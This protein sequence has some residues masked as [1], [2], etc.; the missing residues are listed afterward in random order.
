MSLLYHQTFTKGLFGKY[1]AIF[2]RLPHQGHILEV[3]CHTGYF[4]RFLIDAGYHVIAVET[5][6]E[7]V[8]VAQKNGVSV[9]QANIENFD[10]AI[11]SQHKF[12]VILFMDVLEHL[13][14]PEAV[15]K[16]VIPLLNKDGRILITGPNTVYW[17]VRRDVLRGRWN[18]TD[19]GLL[20]R[21]HLRFYTSSTWYNLF[22]E[23]GFEVIRLESV[24]G[25]V[26]LA[27]YLGRLPL[28]KS[29]PSIIHRAG[30]KLLPN[31]F[32]ITFLIEATPMQS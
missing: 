13:R 11:F 3:G 22:K 23:N 9:I 2:E 16:S 14:Y 30:M 10:P 17:S 32:T 18:Y 28:C 15:L 31:L 4:S 19:S 20:D 25:I 29:L 5:D 24:D 6:Q 21:T 1:K 7:A 27:H 26:P 12:D 8:K